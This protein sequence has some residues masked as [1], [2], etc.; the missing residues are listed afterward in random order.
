MRTSKGKTMNTA[1]T[2]NSDFDYRR[3]EQA[4]TYL[5][6]N[7]RRQPE[8][9][10]V[11]EKL[12]L[13]EFHFQR[14]FRRWAGI[15]PKRF[16]QFLTK[17]HA[18]T[19]LDKSQSILDTAYETGLSGPSRLHDLFVQCEA[20]TPGEYKSGGEGLKIRWGVHETPFGKC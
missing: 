8:L 11:A 19:L 18:R 9:S 17:E 14:L 1:A 2:K 12:C 13:S 6:N 7:Y 16:V 10:E 20:V 5:E 3:I 15:S 4:I